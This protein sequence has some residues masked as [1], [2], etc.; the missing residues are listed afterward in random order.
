MGDDR[1]DPDEI[2]DNFV[3]PEQM[4]LISGAGFTAA[5][6][7]MMK[8]L[9]IDED[10]LKVSLNEEYSDEDGNPKSS[11]HMGGHAFAAFSN[12][13]EL[14]IV[15]HAHYPRDAYEAHESYGY[16]RQF[17]MPAEWRAERGK[18]D[19]YL[20]PS[21]L[22]DKTEF[23]TLLQPFFDKVKEVNPKWNAPKEFNI[24]VRSLFSFSSSGEVYFNDIR[25]DIA[26]RLSC[27]RVSSAAQMS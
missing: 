20:V 13:D 11:E 12:L 6:C 16:G 18:S 26:F 4:E 10:L 17:H 27:G 7:A 15:V 9:A 8:S 1:P 19:M 23:V 3:W 25:A 2:D 24:K 22:K 14:S 5:E 21:K